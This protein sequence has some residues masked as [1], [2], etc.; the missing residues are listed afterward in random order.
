MKRVFSGFLAIVM[1]LVLIS[2]AG[3]TFADAASKPVV[4]NPIT[5]TD[6]NI[7][8]QAVWHSVY[9]GSYPQTDSDG[10]NMEPIKWRVL[11][12]NGNDAFLISDQIL[13]CQPYH[14]EAVETTWANCYIREWLNKYFYSRAF[15][16]A[17]KAAIITTTVKNKDA[18]GNTKDSVYLLSEDEA[19]FDYSSNSGK[20]PVYGF[21]YDTYTATRTARPT[22]YARAKG[23]RAY[24][25]YGEALWYLRTYAFSD[26][27][28]YAYATYR[29][30][31]T[32]GYPDFDIERGIRPVLHLDLSSSVWKYAGLVTSEEVNNVLVEDV[33]LYFADTIL[34]Q[35][36]FKIT[37]TSGKTVSLYKNTST[38]KSY[39]PPSTVVIAN[40]TYKVTGIY[41]SAFSDSKATKVTLGKNIKKLD[42][43]AFQGSKVKTVVVKSKKLTAKTVKRCL[44]N[45]KVKTIK[46][47]VGTKKQ[48]K[49]Y[50]KKYKKI[51]TKKNAGKKVT[52]KIGK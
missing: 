41:Q 2:S 31:R 38:K 43:W 7:D 33:D 22:S 30:G 16:D 15:T 27:K 50:L 29:D 13:D 23:V 51:F 47:Y 8:H 52:V 46:V 40:K 36:V 28:P 17:E 5:Y 26:N 21:D 4:G 39:T 35:G 45:S 6:K 19:V 12:V 1:C 20:N 14:K 37:S 10:V 44:Q 18:G 11:Q 48:N 3:V 49:T 25:D 34:P 24:G 32:F 9:F 42:S